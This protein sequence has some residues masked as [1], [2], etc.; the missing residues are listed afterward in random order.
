VVVVGAIAA[1]IITGICLLCDA[2]TMPV[3]IILIGT[4]IVFVVVIIL[5]LNQNKRETQA[6]FS[7]NQNGI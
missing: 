1:P 7:Q 5:Q 4:A 6:K 2:M 3:G